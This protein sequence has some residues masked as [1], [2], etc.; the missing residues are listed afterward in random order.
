MNFVSLCHMVEASY[1]FFN[2]GII[3]NTAT[4]GVNV[5]RKYFVQDLLS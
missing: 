4:I 2:M 3:F 5:S 1:V